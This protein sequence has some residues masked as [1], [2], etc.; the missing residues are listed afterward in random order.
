MYQLRKINDWFD[1][2]IIMYFVF[3]RDD[4]FKNLFGKSEPATLL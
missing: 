3:C 4:L 2:L 1:D